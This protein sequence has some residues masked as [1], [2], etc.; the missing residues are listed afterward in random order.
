[1]PAS[2]SIPGG[3]RRCLLVVLAGAQISATLLLADD[4]GPEKTLAEAER[5]AWLKNWTRAEPLF[6]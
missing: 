4:T 1:M 2:L 5:L 6:A 3:W